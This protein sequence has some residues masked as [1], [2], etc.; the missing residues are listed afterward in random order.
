MKTYFIRHTEKMDVDFETREFLWKNHK[1]AIHFPYSKSGLQEE[2]NNSLDPEDYPTGGHK[3]AMRALVAIA[4]KGGYVCAQ[5]FP[6]PEY[7][8]GYIE[9]NSKI[10]LIKG[11][12][13]NRGNWSGRQAILKGLSLQKVKVIEPRD[14]VT[15]LVGR[16]RMGTITQWSK[17]GK[18]IEYLVEGKKRLPVLDNLSPDQ[19]ETLCSEFMR[20]PEATAFSLP[21]LIHL[22]LPVGRTMKDIDI[23]GVSAEGK[24]IFAQVTYLDL[25]H[26]TARKKLDNLRKYEAEEKNHLVLFCNCTQ[27]EVINGVLVCPIRQVY[28]RFILTETGQK[29]LQHV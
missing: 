15:L 28:D 25:D 20:L 13:G 6:Y 3:K 1:I 5:Y 24:L 27:P 26:I 22:L 8:I 4:N 10:E 16:P 29:W 7:L 11:R 18:A 23:Y 12:W 21:K 19:Q 2:D 14:S 17:V 9:P